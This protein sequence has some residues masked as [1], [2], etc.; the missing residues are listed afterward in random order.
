[1]YVLMMIADNA[2]EGKV[3]AVACSRMLQD[4]TYVLPE[5][6][7]EAMKHLIC[8]YLCH[9]SYRQYYVGNML[10]LI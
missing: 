1:M 8:S 4:S 10:F 5:L 7:T 9:L 6:C 2:Q 3:A